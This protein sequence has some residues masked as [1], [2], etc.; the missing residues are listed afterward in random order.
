MLNSF[1]CDTSFT[2][3]WIRMLFFLF[4]HIDDFAA[5]IVAAFRA[6][7]VRQAHLAA[8]AALSQGSGGQSIMGAPAVAATLGMFALWMWGHQL[9]LNLFSIT[10]PQNARPPAKQPFGRLIDYT[11]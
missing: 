7:R 2:A 9:L 6:D 4:F 5:F 1:Y 11:G 10:M 3:A 8:V